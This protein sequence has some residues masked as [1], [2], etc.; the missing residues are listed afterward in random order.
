MGACPG[1]H[2]AGPTAHTE[3]CLLVP[4]AQV[5]G[6]LHVLGIMLDPTGALSFLD[7]GGGQKHEPSSA[8]IT[9]NGTFQPLSL[10]HTSE[11]F[12]SE[13]E[14]SRRAEQTV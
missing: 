10:G 9:P 8:T 11:A 3:V 2:S 5:A 4:G 6:L 7:G 13:A 1:Q 12:S 14:L